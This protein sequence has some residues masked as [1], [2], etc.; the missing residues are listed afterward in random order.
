MRDNVGR[1]R[2]ISRKKFFPRLVFC[3]NRGIVL[4][5]I[6]GYRE[7]RGIWVILGGSS[8][9]DARAAATSPGPGSIR[10]RIHGL[11]DVGNL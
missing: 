11:A 6:C 9:R 10:S 5:R 4:E 1:F 3:E 8:A 7:N 2:P